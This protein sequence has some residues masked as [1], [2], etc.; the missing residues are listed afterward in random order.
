MGGI[1]PSLELY[2]IISS[3]YKR[4]TNDSME[5]KALDNI[6]IYI[7]QF[8]TDLYIFIHLL[9]STNISWVVTMCQALL[10]WTNNT[11]KSSTTS[12]SFL[13]Q[14]RGKL[15]L[16]LLSNQDYK[17]YLEILNTSFVQIYSEVREHYKS[18]IPKNFPSAC[19][20]FPAD[21]E[22]V[23]FFKWRQRHFFGCLPRNYFPNFFSLTE[24]KFY[25]VNIPSPT[26]HM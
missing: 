11:F 4:K 24:S 6:N 15:F 26:K 13:E 10:R 23:L 1:H 8:N 16:K 2:W 21:S 12:N 9:Y 20:N 25:S 3:S 17:Y 7:Y 14:G 22:E 19:N 5:S 18:S